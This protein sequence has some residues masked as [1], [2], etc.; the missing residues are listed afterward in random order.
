[1]TQ[2]MKAGRRRSEAERLEAITEQIENTV[3][4]SG[5]EAG[6][7]DF[8]R[9]HPADQADTLLT[10]DEDIQFELLKAVS[11]EQLEEMLEYLEEED[12]SEV[13][14]LLSPQQLSGVLA[15]VNDDLAADIIM[16]VPEDKV[17]AALAFVDTPEVVE[18]I[19]SYPEDSVGSIM[20][21]D[22][23]ELKSSLT[24]AE[25][26]DIL[27]QKGPDLEN[28]YYL[29]TVDDHGV[30]NGVMHLRELIVSK[31]E[32]KLND[33]VSH[34]VI[35]VRAT[36]DQEVASQRLRHYNFV[37][38]PVVDQENHFVG[39][40]TADDVLDV[41]V[42]EATEDMFLQVG[43]GTDSSALDEIFE[44]LKLR[45]PWLMVNLCIGFFSALIVNFFDATIARVAILA[46]FMPII[47]GHG[48]NAGC[49]TTTLVVRGLALGDIYRRDYWSLL[50]KE[51]M[52][53]CVYGL[54]AGVMTSSLAYSLS[55]N[56]NLAA[57]VFIAMFAN[58][59]I[60]GMAG[61]L[62]PL[63][64]KS[65]RI[66]PA[67]ASTVWLTTFTDWAGFFILLGLGSLYV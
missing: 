45:A 31:P 10:I 63:G 21:A 49:Q 39:V 1:M 58:I 40:L 50:F 47:A 55:G 25:A 19:L 34:E 37:A 27:R 36:L 11:I 16:Q 62:I 17:E 51:L 43:L 8:V 6:F 5:F 4:E 14:D 13:I 15:E 22:V 2:E 18:E 54:L 24:V 44:S 61:T 23:V 33:L 64:L 38:L 35:F 7:T 41:Q 65:L 32:Y 52:F 56:K 28:F 46:A 60:A 67:L 20:S 66:D 53:G 3:A 59:I 57:V 42:E 26:F 12:L 48:G 30:L 9:L 29:Y